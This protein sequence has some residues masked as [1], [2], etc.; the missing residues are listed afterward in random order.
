MR[1]LALVALGLCSGAW[2]AEA[3]RCAPG[4]GSVEGRVQTVDGQPIT[5]ARIRVDLAEDYGDVQ[6]FR[7]EGEDPGR[8]WSGDETSTSEGK[9]S[10]ACAAQVPLKFE[11]SHPDFAPT[12]FSWS[13]GTKAH[14][15]LRKGVELKGTFRTET[16]K[17]LAGA[18]VRLT[19]LS[20]PA[21][22]CRRYPRDSKTGP[23][24]AFSIGHLGPGR[25]LLRVAQGDYAYA[26]QEVIVGETPPAP[27][28]L[29]LKKVGISGI[30]VWDDGTPA[31]GV[32]VRGIEDSVLQAIRFYRCGSVEGA[33]G[34]RSTTGADGR[35]SIEGLSVKGTLTVRAEPAE[36]AGSSAKGVQLGSRNLRLVVPRPDSPVGPRT[37]SGVV[38][39]SGA[40]EVFVHLEFS[41]ESARV[42]PGERFTLR[43]SSRTPPTLFIFSRGMQALEVA[44]P[45]GSSGPRDLGTIRLQNERPFAIGAV[46]AET[47][48]PLKN[49]EVGLDRTVWSMAQGQHAGTRPLER[50]GEKVVLWGL[51]PG[52][53]TGTLRLDGYVPARFEAGED[54]SRLEVALTRRVL[55]KPT[56]K[57]VGES[58]LRVARPPLGRSADR[59]MLLV[60]GERPEPRKASD[61]RAIRDRTF[62]STRCGDS[63]CHFAQFQ[64]GRYTVI[65]LAESDD[66]AHLKLWLKTVELGAGVQTLDLSKST[67]AE[68]LLLE[69]DTREAIELED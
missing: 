32:R 12:P 45:S 18:K 30:V 7:L 58:L 47:R 2:A 49:F 25:Y 31:A 27:L 28:Q 61:L 59:P 43:S 39:R 55:R 41:S 69:D 33:G 5:G 14:V 22:E 36:S 38:E 52:K 64:P 9:W 4:Y 16:G 50:V 46:D 56:E 11:L 1:G 51:G 68:A 21:S 65:V 8:D 40:D 24:G 17:P 3:P 23:D 15:V 29:V 10:F 26:T 42:K 67:D 19:P 35:F 13:P 54:A 37:F 63:G 57:P 62:L 44:L 48:A 6:L 20:G 66:D 53:V 34:V 60:M